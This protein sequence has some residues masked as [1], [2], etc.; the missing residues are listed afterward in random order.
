[1]YSTV[2]SLHASCQWIKPDFDSAASKIAAFEK[3]RVNLCGNTK[4]S[5][6]VSSLLLHHFFLSIAIST[7]LWTTRFLYIGLERRTQVNHLLLTVLS[8]FVLFWLT[9]ASCS[10]A[11][12]NL[13]KS[14]RMAA[15]IGSQAPGMDWHELRLGIGTKGLQPRFFFL[16][17]LTFPT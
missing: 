5:S 1:M 2:Y 3:L 7:A 6:N 15:D 11:P 4:S 13:S 14:I 17:A 10:I 12:F 16:G 8:I 9:F